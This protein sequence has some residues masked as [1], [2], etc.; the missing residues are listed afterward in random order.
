MTAPATTTVSQKVA[1]ERAKAEARKFQLEGEAAHLTAQ[2]AFAK[3]EAEV[4]KLD[5]EADLAESRAAE[6]RIDREEAERKAKI[7]SAEDENHHVYVFKGAFDSSS[8]ARCMSALRVWMRNDPACDIEIVFNSPGGSVIDGMALWDF[9]QQVKAAGHQVTTSTIGMAASMGGILLQAGHKRVMG[10][11]AYLLI[12]E[13]AFGAGGKIGEVED[14]VAFV[15]KIQERVVHIFASRSKLTAA[16]IRTKWRRKD[17]WLDSDE[18]LKLGL[19][20]EV[21]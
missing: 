8:V 12:H 18:A 5:A 19:V 4:R 14:E 13:V 11:E 17:W 9:I 16:Q 21:R 20:D 3:A 7:L 15:K 6:A 1:D 2:A 10:R